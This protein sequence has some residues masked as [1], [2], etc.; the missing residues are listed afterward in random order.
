LL[1]TYSERDIDNTIK[2]LKDQLTKSIHHETEHT[3]PVWCKG[4]WRAFIYEPVV[5]R[6][7]R[8]Y[9]ERH[10]VRRGLEPGPYS[11]I[12]IVDP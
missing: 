9:I 4:R 5:W 1:I 6:N 2:W 11:F 3:G 12:E 10:N 8:L 7:T